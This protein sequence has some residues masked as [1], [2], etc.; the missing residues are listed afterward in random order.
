MDMKTKISVLLAVILFSTKAFAQTCELTFSLAG[1]VMMTGASWPGWGCACYGNIEDGCTTSPFSY[2]F[3]HP[4]IPLAQPN[5]CGTDTARAPL[6]RVGN[7]SL[8]P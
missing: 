1:D 7:I 5:G 6:Q 2:K 4:G 8:V 3:N